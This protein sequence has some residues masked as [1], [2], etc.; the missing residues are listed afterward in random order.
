MLLTAR[1]CT[2]VSLDRR[3]VTFTFFEIPVRGQQRVGIEELLE[4]VWSHCS[5]CPVTIDITMLW[6][7]SREYSKKYFNYS[8][9]GLGVPQVHCGTQHITDKRI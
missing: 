5:W 3:E 2:D 1:Q 6:D 7:I 9:L 4:L 8:G